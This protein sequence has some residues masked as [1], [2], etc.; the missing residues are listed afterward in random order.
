MSVSA[1][2]SRLRARH[3]KGV[4]TNAPNGWLFVGASAARTAPFAEAPRTETDAATKKVQNKM[5]LMLKDKK[6]TIYVIN[7]NHII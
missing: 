7:I 2:V 1:T 4:R 5:N 3:C 6:N